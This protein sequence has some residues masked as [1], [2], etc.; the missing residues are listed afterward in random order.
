MAQTRVLACS[1]NGTVGLGAA[2]LDQ[3]CVGVELAIEPTVAALCRR[4]I[5]RFSEAL[6]RPERLLV[7]CTQE[8]PLFSEI[9]AARE[10]SAPLFF[11]NIRERA[12]WGAQ[13]AAAGPKIA[14]LVAMAAS[15]VVDPVPAV[16]FVSR[17]RTL[18]IGNGVDALEWAE[19]LCDQLSVAVLMTRTVDAVLPGERRYPVFSGSVHAISGWL[20]AFEARWNSHNPIDLDACVRCGACAEACPENAIKE[21]LQVDLELCRGH[22]KC[23]AACGA[24]GAIDFSRSE[25]ARSEHFDLVLDLRDAPAFLRSDRPLG[26]FYPGRD[27]AARTSAALEMVQLIGEFEKPK[28][29]D[30][31]P[32]VCAHGRN[33]I[34]GCRL[35]IDVCSTS[36][37]AS[38]GDQIRVEPHL[39]L[40]CGGCTSVC[41]SGALTY[42]TPTTAE[43]GRRLRIGLAA[44]RGRGGREAMVLF[45][46]AEGG[47]RLLD[48]LGRG[49]LSASG[50]GP[51]RA[52]PG[53]RGLPSRVIPV[54][55]AHVA[56]VGIDLVLAALAFGASQ[57]AVLATGRVAPD[58]VAALESQYGFAQAIVTALGYRG[59][60]FSVLCEA[61]AASLEQALHASAPADEVARA[62]TFAVSAEKRRTIESAVEHLSVQRQQGG[63]AAPQHIALPPGAPFG[64]LLVDKVRCTLC[65]SCVGACPEAALLDSLDNPQLR[66]IERHCVQCGL[67]VKTC[68]ERAIALEPRYT[69]GEGSRA[70]RVLNE[71][72][73]CNCVSCGKP[74][75]SALMVE[76]MVGKLTGHPQF[77]G[78]SERRLRMCP[79]CRVIDMFSDAEERSIFDVP[80]AE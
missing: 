21:N 79:D 45:H 41:P 60:H 54:E 29:F 8:T 64:S 13:R 49:R 32:K 36:A 44:Y 27:G 53:V 47:R 59:A 58:Y 80:D 76:S 77:S 70:S 7:T 62:A 57:V 1:C 37:I 78:K 72:E 11:V 74:F 55:V 63:S 26:Y 39:C 24:I 3:P 16:S 14:A 50:S 5:G 56:A 65:M 43:L 15:A 28:Y 10:T 35:C 2:L 40:G 4:D 48:E 20:G 51:A 22:R 46:D 52:A 17:G 33:M 19:R 9:A 34:E 18:I 69:L 67:C 75:A 6:K 23:V 38:D 42:A 66:F 25:V 12:G 68:P 30:Y 31:N 73:P 61:D 71:S